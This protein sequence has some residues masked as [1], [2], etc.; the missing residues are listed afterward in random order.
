[1]PECKS[2]SS[3]AG[4][5][6]FLVMLALQEIMLSRIRAWWKGRSLGEGW[7]VAYTQN[8]EKKTIMVCME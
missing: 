1:M 2:V 4:F 8:D 5:F 7:T 3:E 6:P